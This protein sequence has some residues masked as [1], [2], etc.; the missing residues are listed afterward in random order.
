VL[1]L[2]LL[3]ACCWR[4]KTLAAPS[5]CMRALPA[6]YRTLRACSTVALSF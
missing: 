1:L 3:P 5:L 6:P 4:C 2:L